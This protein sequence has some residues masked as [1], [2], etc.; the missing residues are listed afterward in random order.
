MWARMQGLKLKSKRWMEQWKNTLLVESV[1]S[2]GSI[3]YHENIYCNIVTNLYSEQQMLC[4]PPSVAD[5]RKCVPYFLIRLSVIIWVV[6]LRPKSRMFRINS[7]VRGNEDSKKSLLSTA[8]LFTFHLPNSLE[9]NNM[10]NIEF[11]FE[12]CN[13]MYI[14]KSKSNKTTSN[15]Y[16]NTASQL[17]VPASSMWTLFV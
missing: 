14:I 1:Y 17:L 12:S 8:K 2:K 16:T 9:K 13:N 11:G 10:F 5:N 15:V 4:L 3:S 7:G 6:G